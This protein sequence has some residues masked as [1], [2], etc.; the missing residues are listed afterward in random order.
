MD[1][2]VVL[3][4]QGHPNDETSEKTK[5]V[6]TSKKRNEFVIYSLQENNG[7]NP[8]WDEQF[9]FP[10]VSSCTGSICFEIIDSE[11]KWRIAHYAL[12]VLLKKP[13]YCRLNAFRLNRFGQ[14]ITWFHY[15]MILKMKFRYVI[16]SVISNWSN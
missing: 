4:V 7:Y 11:S 16:Y 5:V 14:G 10:L 15:W 8:S 6:S 12:M 2:Y 9:K 1:P 3:H 13:L